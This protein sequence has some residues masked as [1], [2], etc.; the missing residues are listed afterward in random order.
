MAK[1][2][3]IVGAQAVGKMTVGEALKERTGYS[4]FV[5]HDSLDLAAKIFSWSSSAHRPFSN[6]IREN[7]FKIAVEHNVDMI[8]TFVW[9]FSE[10]SDWDYVQ[11]LNDIFNNELYIVELVT[12]LNT[13]LERNVSE[14]RLEV[15]PTKR[16]INKSKEDI[17]SSL[18]QYRLVSNEGEVKYPNYIK[19]DN[20]DLTPEEV[21]D[22]IVSKFGF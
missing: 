18:E 17:L 15:K 13:R 21:V 12:D 3:L 9:A 19:I 14:H 5:N 20:T 10:Q 11:T 16:D 8:F 22:I 4:L 2:I 1:L 6:S 7:C